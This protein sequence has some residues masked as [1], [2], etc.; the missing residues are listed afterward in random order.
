[1]TEP[2]SVPAS[3]PAIQS[4]G[5][6]VLANFFACPEP[7]LTQKERVAELLAEVVREAGLRPLKQE[8]HQFQPT[9]VTGFVL[10]AESHLSVHTWP[11][12]RSMAVDIF[13]CFLG[14]DGRQQAMDKAERAFQ[15]LTER[16]APREFSK[17]VVMR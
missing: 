17:Q 9:G 1:M 14:S 10:L 8:F 2:S 11:E 6:H 15:A 13:C 4:M 7:L 5:V 16:F 12:H 3:R